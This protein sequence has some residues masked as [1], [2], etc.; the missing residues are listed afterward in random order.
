MTTLETIKSSSKYHIIQY[1]KSLNF[2][3]RQSFP[4]ELGAFLYSLEPQHKP[5]DNYDV[6]TIIR[7]FMLMAQTYGIQRNLHE[8]LQNLCSLEA[9]KSCELLFRYDPEHLF[10]SEYC[11]LIILHKEPAQLREALLMLE[12]RGIL[13]KV[14]LEA[15]LASSKPVNL[16]G[17]ICLLDEK[18]L[19]TVEFI[20]LIERCLKTLGRDDQLDGYTRFRDYTIEKALVE[21]LSIFQKNENLELFKEIFIQKL[22]GLKEINDTKAILRQLEIWIRTYQLL[23]DKGLLTSTN[24]SLVHLVHQDNSPYQSAYL[25]V[26]LEENKLFTLPH[27]KRIDACIKRWDL[28]DTSFKAEQALVTLYQVLAQGYE[29]DDQIELAMISRFSQGEPSKTVQRLTRQIESI[30]IFKG[31]VFPAKTYILEILAAEDPVITATIINILF[32]TDLLAEYQKIKP[33]YRG[34]V[35]QAIQV[36]FYADELTSEHIDYLN[37]SAS[38]MHTASLII[39]LKS[40]ELS[41]SKYLKNLE[42]YLTQLE[43]RGS[44]EV[45]LSALGQELIQLIKLFESNQLDFNVVKES[46]NAAKTDKRIPDSFTYL[47]KAFYILSSK[48]L[49]NLE[50]IGIVSQQVNPVY[51]AC[52]MTILDQYELLSFSHLETLQNCISYWKITNNSFDDVMAHCNIELALPLEHE[53]VRIFQRVL[54]T[55]H[56][57]QGYQKL[58]HHLALFGQKNKEYTLKGLKKLG[59][60]IDVLITTELLVPENL[61]K[62]FTYS[63]VLLYPLQEQDVWCEINPSR[64]GQPNLDELFSMC[65]Y[66]EDRRIIKQQKLRTYA[67]ELNLSATSFVDNN[68]VADNRLQVPPVAH[69]LFRPPSASEIVLSQSLADTIVEQEQAHKPDEEVAPTVTSQVALMQPNNPVWLSPQEQA[70]KTAA[71]KKPEEEVDTDASLPS[72]NGSGVIGWD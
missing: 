21:I 37:E 20:A 66:P 47:R 31:L 28:A 42:L 38:P 29:L 71:L 58:S 22:P 24:L 7:I 2:I 12:V 33:C 6:S 52:L 27:F 35:N 19:L 62:L 57:L 49:L 5:E 25:I 70:S 69:Q 34:A 1:Y 65:E 48:G 9:A 68:K 50:S 13:D 26:T 44:S 30:Q 36:L 46:L 53:M 11:R 41:P 16:A 56:A 3:T 54:S 10:I 51:S 45:K 4:V 63:N 43:R 39:A 17:I 18:E 23:N 72:F 59:Q 61:E 40:F 55:P 32:Q 64:F 14:S 8:P 67:Q 60:A 15:I